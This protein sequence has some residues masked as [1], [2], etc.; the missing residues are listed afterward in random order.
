ML[1]LGL[2]PRLIRNVDLS[3]ALGTLLIAEVELRTTREVGSVVVAR[4]V[5]LA[6]CC[7]AMI[8]GL[9][10]RV[11]CVSLGELRE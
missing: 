7:V 3:L 9:G 8:V 4:R 11:H 2:L 1:A 6:H 5:D 10:D